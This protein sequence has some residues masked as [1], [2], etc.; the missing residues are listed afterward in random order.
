MAPGH[1]MAPGET[2]TPGE[3]MAPDPAA[4]EKAPEEALMVCGPEIQESI[5]TIL[6]L[7]SNPPGASTWKDQLFE[8]TYVLDA[9]NLVLRVKESADGAAA[10]TYFDSRRAAAEN[11]STLKGIASLGLPAYQTSSGIASFVKD[12]MTLEVD[13]TGMTPT[14][15]A[16]GTTRVQFAYTI[17]TNVLACWKEK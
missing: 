15:G 10:R 1:T 4:Q 8:C 9:G 13:A 2:M 11:T 7:P 16:E 17:A 12:N 6:R 5:K 3:T 14:V